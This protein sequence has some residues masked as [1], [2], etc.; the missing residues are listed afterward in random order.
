MGI[1]FLESW[2]RTQFSM[3]QS[4]PHWMATRARYPTPNARLIYMHDTTRKSIIGKLKCEVCLHSEKVCSCN[5][6]V[7]ELNST[8]PMRGFKNSAMAFFSLQL[9]KDSAHLALKHPF[10]PT[11]SHAQSCCCHGEALKPWPKQLIESKNM[12]EQHL[13]FEHSRKSGNKNRWTDVRPSSSV[14]ILLKLQLKHAPGLL[15]PGNEVQHFHAAY[16]E[17]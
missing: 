9:S 12:Q 3:C 16:K 2:P 8:F 15:D 4:S 14:I 13:Y 6:Q 11:P 7:K 10:P 5:N 1:V 17:N